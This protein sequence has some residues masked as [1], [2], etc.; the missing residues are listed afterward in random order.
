M[1]DGSHGILIEIFLI[2]AQTFLLS[3]FRGCRL[4]D[5][6]S[7]LK[8]CGPIMKWLSSWRRLFLLND[9]NSMAMSFVTKVN[10]WPR[11]RY[12][13]W[14]DS[15]LYLSWFTATNADKHNR[16]LVLLVLNGIK[17]TPVWRLDPVNTMF[18]NCLCSSIFLENSRVYFPFLFTDCWSSDTWFCCSRR[19]SDSARSNNFARPMCVVS[20]RSRQ[21]HQKQRLLATDKSNWQLY[22]KQ[23]WSLSLVYSLF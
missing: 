8:V 4:L 2:A 19:R 22:L 10:F 17:E 21:R 11:K 12:R 23:S 6:F 16:L 18:L 5:F 14:L 9:Y 3:Y 13:I 1:I 15:F 20:L 7:V